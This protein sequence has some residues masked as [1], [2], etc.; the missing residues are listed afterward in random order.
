MKILVVENDDLARGLIARRLSSQGCQTVIAA[1]IAEATDAFPNHA[2]D[3]VIVDASASP[4]RCQ[5]IVESLNA[6]WGENTRFVVLTPACENESRCAGC[7]HQLIKPVATEILLRAMV[8]KQLPASVLTQAELS[9]MFEYLY[10]GGERTG[11]SHEDLP[12]VQIVSSEREVW[13]RRVD[14]NNRTGQWTPLP[15][16]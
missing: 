4:M 11:W 15:E 6:R 9:E 7:D 12:S 8:A 2:P 3:L 10:S 5:P 14:A 13:A 1:S 16:T